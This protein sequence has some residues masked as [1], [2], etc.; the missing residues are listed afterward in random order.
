MPTHRVIT[1]LDCL[2]FVLVLPSVCAQKPQ[3]T[4]DDFFN[5]VEIRS[6]QISPGGHEV[7]M[8]TVHSDWRSNRFR[9]RLWLYRDD[10]GGSLVQIT[11]SGLDAGPQ[12]SP[13]GRSIAFLSD[14]S[15]AGGESKDAANGGQCG[16]ENRVAQLYVTNTKSGK[17]FPVTFGEEEIH[18]FAW[19][20]DSRWIYF[21]TRDPRTKKEKEA[22]QKEW[23][24]VVQFRETERGD[25]VFGVELLTVA[26]DATKSARRPEPLLPRRI[27]TSPYHVDQMAASPDGHLLAIT[28]GSRSGRFESSEPYGIYVV[29][30]P[31]GGSPRIVLHTSGP[32]DPWSAASD[33]WSIDSQNIFFSYDFGT[34]DGP[35]EVAQT[36]LY[37]VPVIEGKAT[38]WA[39]GFGGNL[40]SYAI[41]DRGRVICG[42]RLGTEVK[43]Y[44]ALNASAD[45]TPEIS[46]AGTYEHFSAS[47]DSQRVA[48][49]YSS[50]QE[51]TEVY[52]ADGESLERAHPI[53]AFN[54]WF[55]GR[56]LPKGKSYMWKADDGVDIEGML[57]YPPGQFEAK[58][59]PMLV[60]I[61]GGPA[62]AAGNHFEADWYEWSSLAASQ[63]W[64]VFE[65]NFRGSVGYGDAF[66]Q[67]I[68]SHVGSRPGKDVLEG[69]DALVK[70][71]IADPDRL[72]IG[73]YSYGGFL[74]NWLITQTTRF[75]AAITGAGDVE[76]VV[77]WGNNQG[78]LPY[79]YSLG[80]VPWQAT[81]NYN[82]EAPIWYVGN[83]TTPTHIVAGAED[84]TVTVGE[85]YLLERALTTRGIPNSLL[86]FPGESHLL[87]GNPWHG[88]IKVREELKWLEKYAASRSTPHN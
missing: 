44:V 48:F 32:V 43:P 34:P 1:L 73:G 21:A 6:V 59:L 61:H 31:L 75:T 25:A 68:I 40:E 30:L 2:L 38:R 69:V 54:E 78:P 62:E 45:L 86:I 77:N 65:P 16:I 11:Q 81:Q 83:V 18:A 60:S 80:G 67:G 57:I 13:D 88:R 36:R 46:W 8:E 24:D 51:P 50:L 41:A 33:A 52:L 55:K 79:G 47:R 63:G 17:M 14:R 10:G 35:F 37:T 74:T 19:S 27:A 53:T 84:I 64:L 28:T 9:H 72:T 85:D 71:G 23:K 87:E 12:W 26:H 15:L 39:R 70:D 76:F 29:D 42:G 4:L 7:V 56:E 5:S 22:H 58:H 20:S 3:L 82:A 49:A 66:E